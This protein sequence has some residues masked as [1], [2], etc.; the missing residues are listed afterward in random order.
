MRSHHTACSGGIEIV[1]PRIGIHQTGRG[2]ETCVC[3]N[4]IAHRLAKRTL[5]EK[6]SN[7]DNSNGHR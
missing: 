2:H 5:S 3:R 1:R 6:P 7:N 4:G